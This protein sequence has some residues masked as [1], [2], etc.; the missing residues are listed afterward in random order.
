MKR[1]NQSSNNLKPLN[2]ED[3]DNI[4]DNFLHLI[5]S[6]DTHE[7]IQFIANELGHCEVAYCSAFKRN[8][9]NRQK[10][11]NTSNNFETVEIVLG[12]ILDKIHCY[13][14]HFYDIG[15]KLSIKEILKISQYIDKKTDQ[16]ST[17]N[18]S[19]D[20]YMINEAIIQIYQTLHNKKQ[21]YKIINNNNLFDR[22]NKK[23]IL[24]THNENKNQYSFGYTFQYGYDDEP[25]HVWNDTEKFI[26]ATKNGPSNIPTPGP[27]E[28]MND[29][30]IFVLRKYLSLKEELISN[31]IS[32]INI[33][34]FNNEYTKSQIHFRST[35][36]KQQFG[37]IV[38]EESH[39]KIQHILSLMVYC[40]YTQLQYLFS[41]TYREKK[42]IDHCN[43]YFL[44]LHL[45]ILL[46]TFGIQIR[47]GSNTKFYHGIGEK[48]LFPK[49]IGDTDYGIWIKGPL[50]TS[51]SFEVAV[52]FAEKNGFIVEFSGM[53][54]QFPPCETKYFPASW[55]SD[56]AN[57]KEYLF[58]QNHCNGEF[59]TIGKIE[60]QKNYKH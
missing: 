11:Y 58:L 22:L 16:I 34:Q 57:E 2:N 47:D 59:L 1:Y 8:Y 53:E 55:L 24:S 5:H 60:K 40:N 13:Y 23:Y 33:N 50:S 52:N 4:I 25:I 30:P 37:T 14:N 49:Y 54:H 51:S 31:A 44:G 32:R 42:G 43:F 17:S 15:N 3:T 19:L 27:F 20:T 21:T 29:K 26:E 45:K 56:Y 10:Q 46:K 38:C 6:H 7:E 48:L 39:I 41:K 12:Q 9:R 28:I 36:C 18:N 35:Y